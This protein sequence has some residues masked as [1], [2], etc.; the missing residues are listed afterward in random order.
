MPGRKPTSRRY[1]QKTKYQNRSKRGI[2][3]GIATTAAAE[4]LERSRSKWEPLLSR[5]LAEKTVKGQVKILAELYKVSRLAGAGGF[6]CPYC[7]MDPERR[8]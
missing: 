5:A 4:A 7:K 1:G 6:V 8:L 3:T 2:V